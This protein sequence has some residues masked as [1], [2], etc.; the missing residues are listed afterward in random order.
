MSTAHMDIEK[1]NHPT[2]PKVKMLGIMYL[3]FC[4]SCLLTRH[5]LVRFLSRQMLLMYCSGYTSVRNPFS[6]RPRQLHFANS[7]AKTALL[8]HPLEMIQAI[9]HALAN[10]NIIIY[11]S[12]LAVQNLPSYVAIDFCGTNPRFKISVTSPCG[13]YTEVFIW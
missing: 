5:E 7:L 11:V 4:N 1:V 9:F 13:L 3:Q 12:A 6:I 8:L 10:V 2:L